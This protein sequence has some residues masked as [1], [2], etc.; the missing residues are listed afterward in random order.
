MTA[1]LPLINELVGKIVIESPVIWIPGTNDLADGVEDR[2]DELLDELPFEVVNDYV[3]AITKQ[4][5]AARRAVPNYAVAF[6]GIVN[7]LRQL[8]RR[9][10]TLVKS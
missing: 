10:L 1:Y 4:P 7:E 2:I 9:H 6:E 3:V 8:R 5:V